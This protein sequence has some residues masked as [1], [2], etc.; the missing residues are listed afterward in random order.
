MADRYVVPYVDGSTARLEGPFDDFDVAKAAYDRLISDGKGS[1]TLNTLNSAID[2][3]EV[4]YF[5]SVFIERDTGFPE[6]RSQVFNVKN[7]AEEWVEAQN[8]GAVN[9]Q[10]TIREIDKDLAQSWR[11]GIIWNKMIR[12]L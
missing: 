4:K 8:V 11:R 1:V 6:S 9:F 10:S 3:A 2:I 7:K 5:A 12:I